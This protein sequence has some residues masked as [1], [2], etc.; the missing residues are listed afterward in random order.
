VKSRVESEHHEICFYSAPANVWSPG[1]LTTFVLSVREIENIIDHLTDLSHREENVTHFQLE[2]QI[3][4]W[5]EV[6]TNYRIHN[7]DMTQVFSADDILLNREINNM[8]ATLKDFSWEDFFFFIPSEGDI[9]NYRLND[10]KTQCQR[11]SHWKLATSFCQEFRVENW[12]TVEKAISSGACNLLVPPRD[13]DADPVPLSTFAIF[14]SYCKTQSEDEIVG[15]PGGPLKDVKNSLFGFLSDDTKYLTFGAGSEMSFSYSSNIANS[16][17]SS[18]NIWET[19]GDSLINWGKLSFSIGNLNLEAN[20]K[21]EWGDSETTDDTMGLDSTRMASRIIRVTVGDNNPGH[22][23][24]SFLPYHL[25]VLLQVT[26][27]S[28]ELL[29]MAYLG[30]QCS[31]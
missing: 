21:L 14:Q 3:R 26:F 5:N 25:L 24:S 13:A 9:F 1:K 20:H 29:P 7:E 11:L 10:L 4:N 12:I 16:L 31:P 6:L 23:P 2:K 15:L 8:A 28:S 18:T 22:T 30:L 27:M 17:S 19:N